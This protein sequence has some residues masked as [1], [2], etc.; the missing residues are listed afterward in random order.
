MIGVAEAADRVD[1]L[2]RARMLFNQ[3]DFL[4]AVAAAEEAQRLVPARADSA[5][6]I[7]G[8]A[9]VER[10]RLSADSSDLTNARDRLRRINA[11]RLHAGERLELLIGFGETLYFEES[12]GAAAE[13]FDS[14]LARTDLAPDARER[15][16][17]WWA[18]AL[19]RDAGPRADF[20]RQAIYKRMRDRMKSELGLNPANAVASYWLAAAARSQGDWRAAWDATEAAWVRAA[21]SPDRGTALRADLHALMELGI[22]PARARAQAQPVDTLRTEWEAFKIRWE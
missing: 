12:V 15:M 11:G 5:D 2:T 6:L 21:L 10:F 13:V 1:P 17:D 18:T 3:Q 22:L 4:G 7:A 16:L 20:E 14:V 9:Y 8:R 19:H